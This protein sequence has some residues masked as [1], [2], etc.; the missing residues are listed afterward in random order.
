MG[1]ALSMTAARRNLSL[2]AVPSR[3]RQER[4]QIAYETGKR[5]V[6]VWED[7]K[8]SDILTPRRSKRHRGRQARSAPR[9]CP[10]HI[11]AIARHIGVGWATPLGQDRLRHP[12]AGELHAG[13]QIPRRSVPPRRR[14]TDGNA[15]AFGQEK[16]IHGDALTV[17]GK[18]MARTSRRAAGR[19]Q[20][21]KTDKP[22]LGQAGFAVLSGNLS[23]R[24]S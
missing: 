11:N 4:G 23:D 7:L 21:I 24:R 1:T 14:R 2:R 17:T 19:R 22:M 18:T 6:M 10:P 20:V 9:P 16:K 15:R 12:A 3:G 13:R 5:I 8:P